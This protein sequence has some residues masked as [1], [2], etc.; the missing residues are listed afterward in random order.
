MFADAPRAGLLRRLAAL[1]YDWLIL[2]ALW[3]AAMG[4]AMAVVALLNTLGLISMAGYTD[5]ADYI[6]QHKIWF[7]LYSLLVFAWFYLYFWCKGGQTLGMRAWRLL[8]V[9]QNGQPVTLRQALLRAATALFGIGNLW[10]WLRFGKGLALQDQLSNTQV[11][12]LTKEQSK[13]INLHKTAR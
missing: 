7:Q 6:A 8:L 4:L 9:Q 11:V 1:M 10:L 12:V 3:M 2:A 5:H 13:L